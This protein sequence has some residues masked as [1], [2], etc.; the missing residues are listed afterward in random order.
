MSE[1]KS[2]DHDIASHSEGRDCPTDGSPPSIEGRNESPPIDARGSDKTD[3]GPSDR[4][5]ELDP[6]PW[7]TADEPGVGV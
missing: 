6:A 4:S 2:V 7:D 3:Q 1:C 5:E